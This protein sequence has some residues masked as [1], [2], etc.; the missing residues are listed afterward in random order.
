MRAELPSKQADGT[1]NWVEYR[2]SLMSMDKFAV[3]EVATVVMG[4]TGNKVSALAM[5]NDMRNA[6]LGRI[7]TAWSYPVPIPK[8]NN[9]Q[10]ADIVIGNALNLK[11]YS[12]LAK[13]I[14]PLMDEIEGKEL[15]DPKTPSGD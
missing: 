3:D 7:I 1:R 2:D 4:E 6:L 13:A 5:R 14:E 8:E 15:P 10:A 9:F 12:A 11:D